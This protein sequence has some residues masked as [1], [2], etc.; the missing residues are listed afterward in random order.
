MFLGVVGLE[1]LR[2]RE[3]LGLQQQEIKT[4]YYKKAFS[5][6]SFIFVRSA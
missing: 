3:G 6:K 4:Y 2:R 1:L 5:D